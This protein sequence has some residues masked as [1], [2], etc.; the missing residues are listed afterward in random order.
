MIQINDIDDA[1][2][3]YDIDIKYRERCYQ[4]VNNINSSEMFLESFNKINN[5]L[6]KEDFNKYKELWKQMNTDELFCPNIDPFVTNLIILLSYKINQEYIKKYNLDNEQIIINKRR[7][8]EAFESDLINRN[9]SSVRI[10]QMIWA[11]NFVRVNIIEIGRLQYQKLDNN[12]FKIHIPRGDKLDINKVIES[13]NLSKIKLKEIYNLVNIKYICNSWLLSKKLNELID[14]NSNIHK[15]YEL[16]NVYDGDD[17]LNDLLNFVYQINDID[18]YNK[19]EVKTSLQRIIKKEL[20]NKTVFK[21]GNGILKDNY[22]QT[23]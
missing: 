15:F 5:I 13:I 12:T 17:C 22:Y 2:K 16:F 18:D 14:V 6:I 21:T 4:C 19:L 23:R 20:L 11:Y 9:Y 10:S 1:L 7:I 3:Y 8:K